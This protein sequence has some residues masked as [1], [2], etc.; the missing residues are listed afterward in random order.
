MQAG[1]ANRTIILTG[2]ASGIGLACA[3]CFVADGANL[4]SL[5]K[6]EMNPISKTHMHFVV[7]LS[8]EN[9]VRDVFLRHIKGDI[10]GLCNVA[11]IL[12]L[13]TVPGEVD[14]KAFRYVLEVNLMGTLLV[15]DLAIQ[16]MRDSGG[17]SIVNIGSI[18]TLSGGADHLAY[19]IS[20]AGL[21]ILTRHYARRLGR[22]NIRLN[23]IHPGSVWGT[24]LWKTDPQNTTAPDKSTYIQLM[25]NIPMG[26]PLRPEEV[27]VVARFLLS[28]ESSGITGAEIVVDRGESLSLYS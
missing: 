27:A 4:I 12:G 22:F 18:A 11:G 13:R 21:R 19:A 14:L 26:R 10:H 2:A 7:D 16:R 17:G 6:E 24:N 8:D 15:T 28:D 23:I 5:D 25:R 9:Q 1:L 3:K 20:K